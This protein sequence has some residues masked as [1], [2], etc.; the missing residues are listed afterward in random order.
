MLTQYSV[1]TY[2]EKESEEEWMCVYVWLNH[3]VVQQKLSQPCKSTSIKL[4]TKE[5]GV[6]HCG[7]VG[8][9]VSLQR[10]DAGSI[11]GLAQWI[12]GSDLATAAV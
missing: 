8:S 2:M 12:K 3:F 4:S 5:S 7:T 9:V 10:Q 11:L 6:P 1:T